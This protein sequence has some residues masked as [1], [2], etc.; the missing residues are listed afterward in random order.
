M[1][2]GELGPTRRRDAAASARALFEAASELFGQQGFEQTTLREIGER[3]GVDP[4]LVA[5]YFGSKAELYVMVIASEQLDDP[6]TP[7]FA[8]RPAPYEDL[9]AM[10]DAVLRRSDLRGPGPILQSLM[11][12][13]TSGEVREAAR[14]RLDERLVEPLADHFRSSG[15]GAASL[16][17]Q[18]VV[19]ALLGVSLGRS[20]GWFDEL[21]EV[22]RGRLVE[23]LVQVLGPG[24][25]PPIA[26]T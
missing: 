1:A 3:A 11:R 14:A 19:S 12:Q 5:R 21:A 6:T 17:A 16:R 18:L 10:V 9:E 25:G 26:T 8:E 7:R 4:S 22:D 23:L 24:A 20:L 2:S 13:D 15:D